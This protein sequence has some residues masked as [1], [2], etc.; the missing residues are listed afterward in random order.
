MSA[1]IDSVKASA[2]LLIGPMP[3]LRALADNYNAGSHI[4]TSA[5]II[6]MSWSELS[7]PDFH[8]FVPVQFRTKLRRF[9]LWDGLL[10]FP[11][12]VV[13]FS[14]L[15]NIYMGFLIQLEVL[16][17][18]IPHRPCQQPGAWGCMGCVYKTRTI[19]VSANG[20][21]SSDDLTYSKIHSH[22]YSATLM[23]TALRE[24]YEEMNLIVCK[25]YDQAAQSRYRAA[26]T[27]L[28]TELLP[29][30]H[31]IKVPDMFYDY[32]KTRLH[33]LFI[34]QTD[35]C[36]MF[37]CT[38]PDAWIYQESWDKY[39][40][41]ADPD[42]WLAANMNISGSKQKPSQKYTS[43]RQARS[44]CRSRCQSYP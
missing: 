35:I 32:N 36:P 22:S 44:S 2:V 3:V 14:Q 16:C 26:M 21:V 34:T 42:V 27:M 10:K 29:N 8:K 31:N 1:N 25:S 18:D 41:N 19:G 39:V 12:L 13:F 7:S 37:Q 15:D 38:Q 20:K 11:E 28:L 40:T 6:A 43:S 23:N 24:V 9:H 4:D 17:S 5:A 30:K 33:I